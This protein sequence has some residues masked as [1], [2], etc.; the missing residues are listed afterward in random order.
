MLTLTV[1]S[2]CTRRMSCPSLDALL[3]TV[4]GI[5]SDYAVFMQLLF[6]AVAAN[7][8]TLLFNHISGIR[9]AAA[10]NRR[11]KTNTALGFFHTIPKK[12]SFLVH[13]CVKL[14]FISIA[15]IFN[16]LE[17]NLKND[18]QIFKHI[19]RSVV[20]I[21]MF[22][23]SSS[24]NSFQRLLVHKKINIYFDLFVFVFE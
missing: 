17:N 16:A 11:M 14:P 7:T 21:I 22:N 13:P 9:K 24:T 5:R 12:L 10:A 4:Q 1:T 15:C 6:S 23:I 3:Q 19:L 8:A 18:P 2:R 20:V